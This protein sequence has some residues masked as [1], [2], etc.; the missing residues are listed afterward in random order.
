VA[1]VTHRLFICQL[2]YSHWQKIVQNDNFLVKKEFFICEFKIT[3]R[4][5]RK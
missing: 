4:I 5:Y 3:E 1:L 2:A